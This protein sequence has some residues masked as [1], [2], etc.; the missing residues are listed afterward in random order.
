[1]LP[2]E[3]QTPLTL[4]LDYDGNEVYKIENHHTI[5]DILRHI[6]AEIGREE[7]LYF[8]EQVFDEATY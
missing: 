7:M 6:V 3:I 8:A 2:D 5:K 1:M 4:S